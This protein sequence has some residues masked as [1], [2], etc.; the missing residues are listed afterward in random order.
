MVQNSIAYRKEKDKERTFLMKLS[1]GQ[2]T[3]SNC[4]RSNYLVAIREG[5][6]SPR[7]EG[8]R[9]AKRDLL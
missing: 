3:P 7:K 5:Y 8:F 2:D 6:V 4:I 1:F 9:G